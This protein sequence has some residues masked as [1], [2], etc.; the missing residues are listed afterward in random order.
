MFNRLKRKPPEPLNCYETMAQKTGEGPIDIPDAEEQTELENRLDAVLTSEINHPSYYNRGK[1]EVI[2]TIEDW[3][4]G[5]HLGSAIK[6]IARAGYKD[7]NAIITDLRKAVW[8]IN[9]KIDQLEGKV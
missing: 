2:D 7:P 8:Y 1:I 5:F 9:R 4:L 6:Y 3:Q